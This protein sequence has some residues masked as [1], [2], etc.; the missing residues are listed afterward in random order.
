MG[1][2]AGRATA[3]CLRCGFARLAGSRLQPGLLAVGDARCWVAY[4]AC[5]AK[6]QLMILVVLGLLWLMQIGFV[7]RLD[8]AFSHGALIIAMALISIVGGR[9]TP[10]F[11]TGWLR[12]QGLI[13][14]P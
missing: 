6:R 1:C 8:M 11:T 9:I 10:A 3:S 13:P 14:T 7:T 4:L 2:M 5:Q 12:Q